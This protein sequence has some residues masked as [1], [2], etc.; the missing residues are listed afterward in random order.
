VGVVNHRASTNFKAAELRLLLSG[1]PLTMGGGVREADAWTWDLTRYRP[2]QPFVSPDTRSLLVKLDALLGAQAERPY[3][4]VSPEALPRALDHLNVVWKALTQQRLFYPRG[5][6]AAAS[7]VES[8]SSGDELTACL[9]ALADVFDLFMRTAD[10]KAP[11]IGS[12]K[13]FGEQL[14]GQLA[15]TPAQ[16]QARV[17][18]YFNA[19]AVGGIRL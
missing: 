12:L 5:L 18:S 14:L 10:G 6:A 3:V 1:E 13:A 9:G 11:K 15:A 7:L 2:L 16:D 8:V 19:A 17:A 4:P